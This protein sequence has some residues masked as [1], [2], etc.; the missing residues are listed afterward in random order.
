MLREHEIEYRYREY[1][2]EPLSES[3]IRELLAKLALDPHQ[4]LRKRDPVDGRPAVR[5]ASGD[6]VI[7]EGDRLVVAG[8]RSA[9]ESL[10]AI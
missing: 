9:V 1:T 2:E 3:E 4:V 10:D 8:T 5:V 7:D 6:D